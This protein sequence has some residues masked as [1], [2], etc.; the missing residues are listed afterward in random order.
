MEDQ[1][2]VSQTPTA[3]ASRL[4]IDS[5]SEMA[6]ESPAA[7]LMGQKPMQMNSQIMNSNQKP[8]VQLH[9]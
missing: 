5:M 8:S 3:S 6:H 4:L 2:G 1:H 9:Q 7:P